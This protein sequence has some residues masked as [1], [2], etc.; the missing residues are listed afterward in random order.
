[1]KKELI[2]AEESKPTENR[3]FTKVLQVGYMDRGMGHGSFAV[4]NRYGEVVAKVSSNIDPDA[5]PMRLRDDDLANT[6]LFVASPELYAACA[7]ALTALKSAGLGESEA[8]FKL[9]AALKKAVTIPEPEPS[10]KW[11]FAIAEAADES[12]AEMPHEFDD[13]AAA[14]RA[15]LNLLASL[16]TPSPGQVSGTPSTEVYTA[17]IIRPD[18]SRYL[19]EE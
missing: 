14:L 3:E 18:G 4:L 1:L 13:E 11:R 7:T 17:F 8:A 5:V 6:L 10:T 16:R 2:M 9:A 12:P 19:L 15:A